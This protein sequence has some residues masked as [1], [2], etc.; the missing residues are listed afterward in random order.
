MYFS[1]NTETTDRTAGFALYLL[2]E[3]KNWPFQIL[4]AFHLVA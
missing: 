1:E 2:K 3:L 4:W